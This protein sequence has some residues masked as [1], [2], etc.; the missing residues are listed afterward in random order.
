M[1]GNIDPAV[2]ASLPP[3]MQLD[4]LAQMRE[5]LMAENRQKYQ[6]VKKVSY[7]NHWLILGPVMYL[8]LYV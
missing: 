1:D 4:L 3:S 2:L 5:K 8:N 6:K 7:I